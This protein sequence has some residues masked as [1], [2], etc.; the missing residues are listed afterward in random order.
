MP[1]CELLIS[2]GINDFEDREFPI[3]L[4]AVQIM[5]YH[6]SKGLEFPFVFMLNLTSNPRGGSEHVLEQ[7]FN[8]FRENPILLHT[9]EERAFHD[10]F[11]KLYVG[12]SRAQLGL[13]LAFNGR[14]TLSAMGFDVNG[15]PL[16]EIRRMRRNFNFLERRSD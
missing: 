13:I 11:R 1:F 5:T 8:E 4:G 12:K 2:K 3:P 10:Y 7:I 6:Q 9:Q 14:P 16:N 15:D